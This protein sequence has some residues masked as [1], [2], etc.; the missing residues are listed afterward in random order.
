MSLQKT[1]YAIKGCAREQRDIADQCVHA[2]KLKA[3]SLQNAAD[4]DAAAAFVEKMHEAL[5]KCRRHL[6]SH[7]THAEDLINEVE[8][9]L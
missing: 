1:L 6:P 4:M 3:S 9:L 2:P 7:G 8:S 5:K